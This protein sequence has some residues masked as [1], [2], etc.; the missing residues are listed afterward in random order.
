MSGVKDAALKYAEHGFSVIPVKK[1]KK[2]FL[3]WIE[4]QKRKAEPEEIKEWFKS[5]PDAN[6]AIVTGEISQ[7]VVVD[8]DSQ[9]GKQAFLK[10]LPQDIF[11]PTATTPRGGWHQYF[12]NPDKTIGN[13]AGVIPGVD[14]R[15]EGGY[16][17][18]PPSVN[19]EGKFYEWQPKLSIFEVEPPPLPHDYCELINTNA[20]NI[21]RCQHFVDSC[22]GIFMDGRRDDDVFHLAFHLLKGKMP[23]EEIFQHLKIF[24]NFDKKA[25]EFFSEKQIKEKIESAKKRLQKKEINLSQEVRSWVLST[26]GIFSSTDVHYCQQLSTRAEKQNVHMIL[27]RLCEEGVIEKYGN[28]NGYFRLIDK[29]AEEID[30]INITNES[31]WLHW[32][33]GIERYVKTL[34]KNI[35]I[36]A[37]SSNSGKTA[38]LLNFIKQNM[39]DQDIHYFSSEMGGME[40]NE[41]LSKFDISLSDWRF[42]VKERSSNFA[43]VIAPDGINIIDFLEIYDEFYKIGQPI[44]DIYEKLNKGIAIIAIQ[45]NLNTNYGLGGQRSLEKARLYLAMEPGRLKIVKA[46]NWQTSL[47][48]NGL[49]IAFKLV[50]GCKFVYENDW[51]K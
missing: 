11:P 49:E 35:I 29:T 40:L 45:K 12:R 32:P 24:A 21:Y 5:W 50:Q 37:G 42:T 3:P 28:R 27:K 9:E 46:K 25:K 33:F 10:L 18:A 8:Q 39:K 43:D 48:P 7:M 14:F 31:L 2:P 41:R 51:T 13:N 38:F 1:D 36:I 22:Q 16:V 6:I 44:K 23:E 15:G 34:P 4:Y 20:V 47:N 26:N 30:F 19:G 17:V